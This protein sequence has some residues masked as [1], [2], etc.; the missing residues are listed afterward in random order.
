MK[1]REEQP[2]VF[3]QNTGNDAYTGSKHH[4]IMQIE[5]TS[6]CFKTSLLLKA[7]EW[8]QTRFLMAWQ[9]PVFK[10]SHGTNS[11]WCLGPSEQ[12]ALEYVNSSSS[13]CPSPPHPSH[14]HTNVFCNLEHSTHP[15]PPPGH[16]WR[17]KPGQFPRQPL[18]YSSFY[19]L[20]G[21]LW[22]ISHCPL[23]MT[24]QPNF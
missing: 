23:S 9:S 18:Q 19:I 15:S 7:G 14:T 5:G 12:F 24:I 1:T 22:L 8:N 11:I 16:L 13:S 3:C 2:K 10:T 20:L 17:W 21:W 6:G 4:K